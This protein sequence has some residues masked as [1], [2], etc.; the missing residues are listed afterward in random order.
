LKLIGLSGPGWTSEELLAFQSIGA[1]WGIDVQQ[2]PDGSTD[3]LDGIVAKRGASGDVPVVQSPDLPCLLYCQP[4]TSPGGSKVKPLTFSNSS[5]LPPELRGQLILDN[6]LPS[7][8][9]DCAAADYEALAHLGDRTVWA[10]RIKN[11]Q[12]FLWSGIAP[13]ALSARHR[14][15]ESFNGDSLLN[16]LPAWLFFR[17]LSAEYL[18]S[19]PPLRACLIIDDPNLHWRS[20]GHINYEL[21]AR[22]AAEWRFHAAIATVPIDQWWVNSRAAQCFR[23][24][25]ELLS[26]VVHGN[27]HSIDEL[28]RPLSSEDR[29]RLVTESLFR[30]SSLERST[31]IRVDRVMVPPHGVC[32]HDILHDL[33]RGGYQGLT[34]NRW[35]LWRYVPPSDLPVDF[36]LRPADML[37][38]GLPVLPRFRFRSAIAHTEII[39]ARLL[40]QPLIPYGHERDFGDD[41]GFVRAIVRAINATGDVRWSSIREI[42]ET[43]FESRIDGELLR[44]RMYSREV[45]SVVPSGILSIQVELPPF[46][47]DWDS[48]VECRWKL[49]G[50]RHY[51]VRGLG[52]PI[53]I[54]AGCHFRV[55]LV[56]PSMSSALVVRSGRPPTPSL[57]RLAAELRDRLLVVFR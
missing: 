31:R 43:N 14:L 13:P 37:A 19:S 46:V 5:L 21:L 40:G 2:R 27:D 36:G 32:S 3:N 51:V 10:G 42:L 6:D 39:L 48:H 4:E 56:S 26:L 1:F 29:Y 52:E 50:E 34:T 54:P 24:H 41:M 16:V 30:I 25:P 11:D 20:Y 53:S 17:L 57:R 49:A 12:L 23:S 18:W 28:A 9:L 38:R 55:R 7:T 33:W 22:R 44:I 15:A 47:R 8:V 35:S 45:Y